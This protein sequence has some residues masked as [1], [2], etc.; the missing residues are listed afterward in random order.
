MQSGTRVC[1]GRHKADCDHSEQ[2]DKTAAIH[3]VLSLE[4]V[5]RESAPRNE[6]SCE[7]MSRVLARFDERFAHLAINGGLK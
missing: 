7:N 3:R 6:D 1:S 4:N 5:D 2:S